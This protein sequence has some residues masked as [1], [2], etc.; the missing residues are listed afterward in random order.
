MYLLSDRSSVGLLQDEF[1]LGRIKMI[2]EACGKGEA[3][4]VY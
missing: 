2:D 4:M 3:I 1:M